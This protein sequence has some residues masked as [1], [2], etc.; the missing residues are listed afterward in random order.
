MTRLT[1]V[2]DVDEHSDDDGLVMNPYGWLDDKESIID[3][4]LNKY[5]IEFLNKAR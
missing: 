3:I 5:F 2:S 4:K 1:L